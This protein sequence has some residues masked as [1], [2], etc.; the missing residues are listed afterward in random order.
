MEDRYKDYAKPG[1]TVM[2]QLED[3]GEW[4]R[5]ESHLY[6]PTRVKGNQLLEPVSGESLEVGLDVPN[7]THHSRV[8]K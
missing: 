6:L 7:C 1:F 2:G 5:V 8:S 4:L 3:G